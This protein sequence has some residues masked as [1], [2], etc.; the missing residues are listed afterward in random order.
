MIAHEFEEPATSLLILR[1]AGANR[2]F[3][4]SS[5]RD[6]STG[7]MRRPA[8]LAWSLASPFLLLPLGLD[9][10]SDSP[11]PG[12]L[13]GTYAVVGQSQTN[14]CGLG[15]PDPWKF[16]VQL[17]KDGMILYWSWLDGSPPASSP[18]SAELQATLTASQTGNVD[19]TGDG[20]VGPCTMAR[21]DTIGL[22]L[23]DESPPNGFTGTLSYVFSVLSGSNCADQLTS[24]GGQYD[25][26]P[27]TIAYSIT[28]SRQ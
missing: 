27:C 16:D 9:G 20:G 19:G 4:P 10:C 28:A 7:T 23:G 1:F 5:R 24:S 22:T 21:S 8:K 25:A 3:V 6:V 26:L 15:A 18:L 14:T 13:L 12:T 2:K 11:L 17:S